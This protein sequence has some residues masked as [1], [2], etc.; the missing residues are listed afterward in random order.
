MHLVD[1]QAIS[2]GM[3]RV[4]PGE[5]LIEALEAL[6]QAAG[7][8]DGYV[9]GAGVLELVELASG[10][11]GATDTLENAELASLSGRI[12]HENNQAVARLRA[13]VLVDGTLHC[14]RIVA[15]MTGRLLLVVEAVVAQPAKVAADL[16]GATGSV[17]AA[18]S[19][20]PAVPPAIRPSA[21][22]TEAHAARSA[23]KPLSQT[24]STKP[25]PKRL[26][27]SPGARDENPEVEPGD[28]LNHPQLGMCE[29]VGDDESGGTRIRVPSGRVRV[30]RLDAL[31]V[32]AGEKDEQGRT[33]FRVAGP[34]RRY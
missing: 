20:P 9:T 21:N 18:A 30:L 11:D 2:R 5:D 23:T 26:P 6:A 27:S 19:T 8:R 31:Q 10:P 13:T 14:G 3:V 4:E 28:L 34:R 16:G 7:W 33:V 32:L 25:I 29:V 1:E 12:A 22:S 24:F 15:A 17:D